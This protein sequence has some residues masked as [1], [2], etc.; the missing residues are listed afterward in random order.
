MND[1]TQAFDDAD[2]LDQLLNDAKGRIQPLIV[3]QDDFVNDYY[4]AVIATMPAQ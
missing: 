1:T 3:S 4:G 2:Q